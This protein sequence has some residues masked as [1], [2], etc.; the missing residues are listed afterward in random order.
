MKK[1]ELI[2][3]IQKYEPLLANAVSHM[4]ERFASDCDSEKQRPEK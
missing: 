2:K 1:E 3:Q 4:A